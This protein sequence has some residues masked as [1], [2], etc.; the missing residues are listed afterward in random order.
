MGSVIFLPVQRPQDGNDVMDLGAL[1]TARARE[2][3]SVW[4]P[5]TASDAKRLKA[6]RIRLYRNPQKWS[7]VTGVYFRRKTRV[8]FCAYSSFTSHFS[9]CITY[10]KGLRSLGLSV[11]TH[12]PCSRTV[13]TGSGCG[14]QRQSILY[15]RLYIL[16]LSGHQTETLNPRF[17]VMA[18]A[19][20]MN[21]LLAFTTEASACR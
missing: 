18:G 3:Y 13:S 8:L 19:N 11:Y 5:L 16:F 15:I 10:G 2:Y 7:S 21:V 20:L 12:Y 17:S 14:P 9:S 4:F 6:S 1:T